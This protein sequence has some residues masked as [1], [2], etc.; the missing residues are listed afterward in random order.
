M[1]PYL[2][3]GALAL[4]V[5]PLAPL[6]G[7]VAGSPTSPVED[8]YP[9]A[10]TGALR[11][12]AAA[13]AIT[14]G[15]GQTEVD[16]FV[17]GLAAAFVIGRRLA[18]VA[19][20]VVAMTATA[21]LR[22]GSSSLTDVTGAHTV[23]GPALLSPRW[24]VWIP[25]ALVLAAGLVAVVAVVPGP[26]PRRG[27]TASPDL[28]A[29]GLAPVAVALVVLV[30]TVGP[31]LSDAPDAAVWTSVRSA[32]LFG[33]LPAAALAR[34]LTARISERALATSTAGLAGVGLLVAL[35]GA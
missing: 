30:V 29:D 22:T 3:G 26:A 33:V 19:V 21:A 27:F 4:A 10:V 23:L 35:A 9:A 32:V 8:G 17:L 11:L 16:V 25:A 12:G 2:V 7:R 18:A 34:R 1:I 13:A 5:A 15:V 6:L 31:P 28:L 24:E 20:A 14:V